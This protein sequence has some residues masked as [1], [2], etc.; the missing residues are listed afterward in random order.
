MS[1]IKNNGADFVENNFENEKAI[2]KSKIERIN[3]IKMDI[4]KRLEN[5]HSKILMEGGGVPLDTYRDSNEESDYKEL[6]SVLYYSFW[7]RVDEDKR[8][9]GASKYIHHDFNA[10]FVTD[11]FYTKLR[12]EDMT[13]LMN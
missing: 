9:F 7:E 1:H 2:T 4:K 11:E 3:Q 10:N 6:D 8:E 12:Q 13:L 5:L